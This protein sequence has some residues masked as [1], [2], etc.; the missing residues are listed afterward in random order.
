MPSGYN[1]R[2]GG[3][4]GGGRSAIP[5]TGAAQYSISATG[6]LVYVPGGV[7]RTLCKLVWVNRNGIEQPLVAPPR[8]YY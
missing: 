8:V 5:V 4:R 3:S 2:R 6:S 7:R 1:Y